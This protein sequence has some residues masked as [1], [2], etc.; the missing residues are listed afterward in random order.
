MSVLDL[1]LQH[2]RYRRVADGKSSLH[3]GHNSFLQQKWCEKSR[4]WTSWPDD[5]HSVRNNDWK[6]AERLFI[7][8]MLDHGALLSHTQTTVQMFWVT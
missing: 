6:D 2:Q 5:T 4:D 3:T 7:A 1:Q 8:A